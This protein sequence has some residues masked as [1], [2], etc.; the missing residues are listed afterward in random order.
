MTLIVLRIFLLYFFTLLSLKAMGKRQVGELQPI[1]LVVILIISEM[2][3]LAMQSND[4]PL[5]NSLI[6]IAILTVIQIIL[7]LINLKNEKLRA[8]ICGR[9]SVIIKEGF[10]NENEMRKLRMNINDLLEQ[11]RSQGYFDVSVIDYAVMETNGKLSV[12]PKMQ[13]RPVETGDMNLA[14][15]KEIPGSL[16][17]LDGHINQ[18]A[19]KDMNKDR[20]WL[21][22]VLKKHNITNSKNIFIAG[23]DLKGK[24]FYQYKNK[25]Q[26]S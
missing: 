9:P 7:S 16:L 10:V 17:I 14:L 24:F 11:L 13:N 23:L 4:I 20:I 8:L 26:R 5:T 2:A 21:E 19:L 6:P 3:S 1:E 22:D 25:D 12:L 15:P 18:N